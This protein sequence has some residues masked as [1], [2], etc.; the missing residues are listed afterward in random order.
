V[1]AITAAGGSRTGGAGSSAS[2][3][4]SAG[5]GA[6]VAA[7]V[8]PNIVYPDAVSGN[9]RAEVRVRTAPDGTITSA[10]ISKSSGNAAW[11][12]AVVRALHKT[13][14]LPRDIDGKVPS[15]L[16]IGFRP[17]D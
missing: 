1:A 10:T 14:K 5:Y 9:P 3:G 8:K 4:P 12:E 16:V 6:K 2:G 15:D 11:D 17:Q 13:D 7:R